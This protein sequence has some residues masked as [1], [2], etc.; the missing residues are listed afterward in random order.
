MILDRLQFY[1]RYEG[2]HDGFK[3]AF[4]FLLQPNLE[5]LTPGRIDIDGDRIFAILET[6]PGR[7]IE[8]AKLE[9]HRKYI[10]I[11]YVITNGD[12]MGWHNTSLCKRPMG[13]YDA[14]KDIIF[15]RDEPDL[16]VAVPPGAF[17]IFF[18]EDAHAPLV[19]EGPIFK[20]IIKVAV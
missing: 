15:F 4:A 5:Q 3:E 14:R 7:T 9:A 12:R 1:E 6:A 19:G 18:P 17:A 13:D 11:Q 20:A 8:E 2:L 10:D 16:W